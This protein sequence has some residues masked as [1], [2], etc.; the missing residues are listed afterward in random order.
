MNNAM[1]LFPTTVSLQLWTNVGREQQ[2]QIYAYLQWVVSSS[3]GGIDCI[4][5]LQTVQAPADRLFPH[6]ILISA[7]AG[8]SVSCLLDGS[9]VGRLS[10]CRP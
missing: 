9:L 10:L 6:L 3:G 5:E 2:W 8:S 7:N 4:C 1:L